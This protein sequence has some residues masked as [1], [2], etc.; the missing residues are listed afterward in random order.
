MPDPDQSHFPGMIC[1]TEPHD[2][3]VPPAAPDGDV[4]PAAP[5]GDVP[6]AAPD[7]DV[8]PATPAAWRCT[9]SCT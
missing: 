7:G 6:P 4:P 1:C 5:D 9:S 8:P 3:D 2:G